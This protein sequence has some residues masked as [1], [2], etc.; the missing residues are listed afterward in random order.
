MKTSMKL[1]STLTAASILVGCNS[2]IPTANPP[3]SSP[4]GK[5]INTGNFGKFTNKYR[6]SGNSPAIVDDGTII[7]SPAKN[8]CGTNKQRSE[9]NGPAM[10][11]NDVKKV[12]LTANL[13]FKADTEMLDEKGRAIST[14]GRL[15]QVASNPD[16]PKGQTGTPAASF[17]IDDYGK[18]KTQSGYQHNPIPAWKGAHKTKSCSNNRVKRLTRTDGQ[19]VIPKDGTPFDLKIEFDFKG[20]GNFD[21]LVYMDGKR[22]DAFSYVRPAT[23]RNTKEFKIKFGM[24]SREMFDYELVVKDFRVDKV[25]KLSD[26]FEAAFK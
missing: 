26:E 4:F 20:K 18:T 12:V 11:Q 13:S 6:C 22:I 16:C 17:L 9:I 1:L 5:V 19:T 8:K 24:Y 15:F 23:A 3:V 14:A 7:F 21:Y 2:T 10:S 25:D